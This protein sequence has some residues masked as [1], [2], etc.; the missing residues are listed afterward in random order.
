MI[1][2]MSWISR[3]GSGFERRLAWEREL[4]IHGF[5]LGSFLSHVFIPPSKWSGL[6]DVVSR[7]RICVRGNRP[8]EEKVGSIRVLSEPPI[9]GCLQDLL[10]AAKPSIF[11]SLLYVQKKKRNFALHFDEPDEDY[12]H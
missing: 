2:S 10:T 11:A 6:F 8:S 3:A 12:G 5:I 7:A 9:Y 1:P 4:P